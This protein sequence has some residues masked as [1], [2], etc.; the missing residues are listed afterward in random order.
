MNELS[1]MQF[2][3]GRAGREG[4]RLSLALDLQVP[5][6]LYLHNYLKAGKLY[7][8]PLLTALTDPL[9]P[10]DTFIDIGA[11][12]GYFS[13]LALQMILPG[14]HVYAFE[15]NPSVFD[16]L[17]ANADLNDSG[18]LQVFKMALG[19]EP[20][21]ANLFINMTDVGMSTLLGSGNGPVTPVTVATLDDLHARLRFQNVRMVKIDVEGFEEKVIRGGSGFFSQ[22]LAESVVF[23]VNPHIAGASQKP[24]YQ[25]RRFFA[26]LGYQ[27]YL[28]RTEIDP[29]WASKAFRDKLYLRLPLD[30]S[31]DMPFGNILV[32]A[33]QLD[34]ASLR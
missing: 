3:F 28:I 11:N 34:A 9:Q 6:Q 19:D 17:K 5:P 31:L 32:T 20:G 30:G 14:G 2:R 27:A 7:D 23:E 26:G 1:V 16:V 29:E 24:D 25:I 10:G 12:I 21:T 15:P 4:K 22:R 13:V 18:H 33:R 8:L